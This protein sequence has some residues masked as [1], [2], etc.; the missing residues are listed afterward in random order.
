MLGAGTPTR[1]QRLL[2]TIA[3][4][5][6]EAVISGVDA[7]LAHG[8]VVPIRRV[9]VLVKAQR[10]VFPDELM[11]ME[12]TTRLPG[13]Q[14]S[15]R[16][17]HEPAREHSLGSFAQL[18]PILRATRGPCGSTGVPARHFATASSRTRSRA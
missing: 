10:K 6:P 11:I 7:L 12:R 15:R 17:P 16:W 13:G 9:H 18:V 2:A 5:G 8:A 1:R 4:L 3:R 14:G